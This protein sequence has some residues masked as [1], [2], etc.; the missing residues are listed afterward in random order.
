MKYISVFFAG[1]CAT[2][3]NLAIAYTAGEVNLWNAL[4]YYCLIS[5]II[6]FLIFYF[7]KKKKEG[8]FEYPKTFKATYMVAGI[9]AA[10]VPVGIT[11]GI[12]FFGTF[13]ASL[14]VMAGQFILSFFIDKNGWFSFPKKEISMKQLVYMICIIVGVILVSI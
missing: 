10:L 7:A 5:T 9:A 1:V 4:F 6:T 8:K 3:T 2:I 11:I 12:N 14:A 13:I